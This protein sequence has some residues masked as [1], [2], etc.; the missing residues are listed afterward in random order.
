L[1]E[2]GYTSQKKSVYIYLINSDYERCHL[3]CPYTSHHVYSNAW[4]L[5]PI[6]LL[7]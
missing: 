2:M 1:I 4:K 6:H 5:R 7:V 3:T